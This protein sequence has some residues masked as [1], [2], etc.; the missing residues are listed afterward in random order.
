MSK[1][2]KD[3]LL[4]GKFPAGDLLLSLAIICAGASVNAPDALLLVF[5]HMSVLVYQDSLI[6][7]MKDIYLFHQLSHT[8]AVIKQR[9][10]RP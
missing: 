6:I 10:R 2:Q 5:K 3:I 4:L 9:F 8:G 1:M 7:T